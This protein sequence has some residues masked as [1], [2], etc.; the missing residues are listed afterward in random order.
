[1]LCAWVDANKTNRSITFASC[2]LQLF[3]SSGK[4][5]SSFSSHAENTLVLLE[6]GPFEK[7]RAIL[8]MAGMDRLFGEMLTMD[9]KEFRILHAAVIPLIWQ[10]RQFV[11]IARREYPLLFNINSS[12]HRHSYT[13]DVLRESLFS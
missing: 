12:A 10:N 13:P 6:S 1:V 2:T 4:T 5:G 11:L 9:R 7:G 8:D 3:L